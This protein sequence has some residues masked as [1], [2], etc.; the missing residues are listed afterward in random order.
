MTD[1]IGALVKEARIAAGL[2]QKALAEAVDGIS[3]KRISEAERGL[4]ELTD[5]Q[6]AAIA[7]ATGSETLLAEAKEEAPEAVAEAP[8]APAAGE[9]DIL[10]L[11]SSAA[12][13][14]KEAAMSVL[15]G[16][17]EPQSKGSLADYLPML[18]GMLG[19]DK[20]GNPLTA[21]IGFLGSEEGKGFMETLK[22]ALDNF[23]GAFGMAA[24]GDEGQ[25]EVKMSNSFLA[26]TFF[27]AVAIYILLISFY[28]WQI[29]TDIKP[30]K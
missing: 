25:G 5:E 7:E 10:E 30:E 29:R 17:E 9:P 16:G 23:T 19:G 18:A 27:Y 22:G 3:A 15:K 21:I 14:V 8:E 24:G 28:F 11:L 13:A 4:K 6:L 20:G 1:Q 26:F 2:T 12:P